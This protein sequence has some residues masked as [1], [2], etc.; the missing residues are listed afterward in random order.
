MSRFRKVGEPWLRAAY[1]ALATRPQTVWCSPM[2]LAAWAAV[3]G[4]W[5]RAGAP[6]VAMT[7]SSAMAVVLFRG[8]LRNRRPA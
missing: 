5:A 4:A 1:L 2:W 3:S 6:S 8:S 7:V